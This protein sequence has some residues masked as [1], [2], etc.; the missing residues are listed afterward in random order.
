MT[1]EEG[2]HIAVLQIEAIQALNIEPSGIYLDGTYGRGG[3]SGL[4]LEKLS[5][6]GR[7]IAIDQDPEAIADGKQRFAADSRLS[8]FKRNFEQ[9]E[10]VSIEAGIVGE[11]GGILLDLG[12][13]SPQLDTPSRGFS[14]SRD[15]DLDMRMDT[16]QGE[17]AAT[18]LQQVSETELARVLRDYGDERYAKR[19]AAAVIDARTTGSMNTTAM[20]AE[21]VKQAHPRWDHQRHPATKTFQ[22]IRIFINRELAVLESA[23]A[24]SARVLRPGGRL[25][26]ISFHSLEDRLVKRFLRGTDPYKN[27]P[28][29]LPLPDEFSA[30]GSRRGAQGH[31]LKALGKKMPG[32]DELSVNPRA[33]SAVLRVAERVA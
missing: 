21:V 31:G 29:H 3:H 12:V 13:S 10:A 2:Q 28:R 22:A 4:I 14:F 16:E 18:W 23:L 26:V 9:L 24:Q 1:T 20:L 25:V 8:L 7:L 17:S 15:G 6:D 19:I 11:V 5:A 27:V 32:K 30:V 33:R